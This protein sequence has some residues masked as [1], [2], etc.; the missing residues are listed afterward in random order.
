[1]APE[2]ACHCLDQPWTL[3]YEPAPGTPVHK[4]R[5]HEFLVILA[6][7]AVVAVVAVVVRVVLGG[8]GGGGGGGVGWGVVGMAAASSPAPPLT[9]QHR[10]H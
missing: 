5:P 10:L 3:Q 6:A 4:S 7:V 2:I 1:M 9:N 8:C